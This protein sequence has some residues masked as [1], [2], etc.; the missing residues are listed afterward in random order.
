MPRRHGLGLIPEGRTEAGVGSTEYSELEV[1]CGSDGTW[2]ELSDEKVQDTC[3]TQ[4]IGDDG[5][6]AVITT[7][8]GPTP[9][10]AELKQCG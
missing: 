3:S 8:T 6:M 1:G 7:S 10:R 2:L 4:W 9:A 5:G